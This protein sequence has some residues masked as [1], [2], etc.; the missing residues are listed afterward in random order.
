MTEKSANHANHANH[1]QPKDYPL[2]VAGS[3]CGALRTGVHWRSP[4]PDN[5]C[6]LSLTLLRTMLDGL[7]A[8]FGQNAGY[9]ED[10]LG[11]IE[12]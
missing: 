11:A 4:A 9:T 7:P 3:A 1:S 8:S 12:L 5:A 2:I 10:S 6:K